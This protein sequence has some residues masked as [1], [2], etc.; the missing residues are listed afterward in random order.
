MSFLYK[1][2]ASAKEI[3]S[4]IL[5]ITKKNEVFIASLLSSIFSGIKGMHAAIGPV[6]PPTFIR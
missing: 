4:C 6:R 5:T 3:N 1:N 2:H